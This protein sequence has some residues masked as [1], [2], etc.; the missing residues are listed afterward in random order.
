M[1]EF[2]LVINKGMASVERRVPE[3][4]EQ[5]DD[6]LPGQSR[7]LF[8]RLFEHLRVLDRQVKELDAQIKACHAE[9]SASQRLAAI[10]GHWTAYRPRPRSEHRRCKDV[11]Q[12]STTRRMAWAGATTKLNRW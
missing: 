10:P 9:D 7:A 5:A 3:I 11:S 12:R 8:A 6:G 1:A 4:L 2:G